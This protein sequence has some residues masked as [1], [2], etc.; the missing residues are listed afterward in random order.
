[1]RSKIIKI[2]VLVIAGVFIIIQFIHPEKNISG[3]DTY[4]VEKKYPVSDSL[5]H[6]LKVACYDCHSNKTEYPWYSEIQPVAWW[7]ADHVEEGKGHL[8]FSEFLAYPI[9]RQHHKFKEVIE[10][11][12][13]KEMPLN[14]Y[15]WLGMHAEADISEG[16][17]K[18]IVDWAKNNMQYLKDNYPPDSLKMNRQQR[19][20]E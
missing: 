20:V 6:L 12:E 4:A 15:T 13:E 19:E 16:Q 5:Q 10:L 17:R 14:N 11:V 18:M 1:M 7:L 8:N 2:I 9:A 3:D